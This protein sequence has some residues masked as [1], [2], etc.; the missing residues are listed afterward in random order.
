[1]ALGKLF[2]SLIGGSSRGSDKAEAESFSYKGFVIEAAPIE[3]GSNYRTAGYISGE[4]DGDNKRIQ[5]I[6]ADQHGNQQAAI[7]HAFAK[8]Q[9][10]IDEQGKNLL[11]KTLL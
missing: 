8:G 7:D 5:F 1:M 2:K 4:L 9:Q 3:E 11:K 6:R 10:I